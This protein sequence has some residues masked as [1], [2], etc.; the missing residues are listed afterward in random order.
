MRELDDG[1]P[2]WT[3][4]GKTGGLDPL[5]MLAPIEQLYS[6]LLNGISS[7]TVRVR[8]YAFFAW[9][10]KEYGRA[11][12]S[13]NQDDLEAHIRRG[14]A[15][16]GL[17]SRA[18][19]LGGGLAGENTFGRYLRE[20]VAE[21]DFLLLQEEY[22]EFPA[23]FGIYGSQ[24][25]EMGVLKRNKHGILAPTP[26]LGLPLADAF[27][28]SVG[29][30][31]VKLFRDTCLQAKVELNT[32]QRMK[33]MSINFD[34][35]QD[36]TREL[37]LLR[38]ALVGRRGVGERRNTILEILEYSRAKG[39]L[40]SEWLMRFEWLEDFPA[41]DAIR[42][43]ERML[44]AHFQVADSMRVSME[45]I[46]RFCVQTLSDHGTMDIS[47]LTAEVCSSIPNSVSLEDYFLEL[48]ELA[49]GLSTR[50][51]QE[52][53][54]KDGTS[55]E[56]KVTLIAKL[57]IDWSAKLQ[58]MEEIF[59]PKGHFRTSATE[60][61]FLSSKAQFNAQSAIAEFIR[62][63]ILSRHLFV[64]SRK[65]RFQSNYTFQFEYEEGTVVAR[66][67][68]LVGAAGPRLGTAIAFLTQLGLLD[69][70]G[71]TEIGRTEL[72]KQ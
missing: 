52:A 6:G 56:P 72:E 62:H 48:V 67:T 8:Y 27:E 70:A 64:A 28:E 65:L 61:G 26:E 63:R 7:V 18:N 24:M 17:I 51:I 21:Y 37:T 3:D 16:V 49:G 71:L 15:L 30:Q 34:Q 58:D 55:L 20:D 45:S 2:Y 41:A 38:E 40:P 39:S 50:E 25:A 60:I 29:P 32:L 13:T 66:R 10:M 23:F 19:D 5:A 4:R 31:T 33:A 46:L 44:W 36:T 11:T 59:P 57:W 9:W 14:E 68:G 53:A 35:V 43:E 47:D 12:F 69:E 42:F 54:T 1:I 22:L